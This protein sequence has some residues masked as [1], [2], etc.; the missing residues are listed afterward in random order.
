M[1]TSTPY[2]NLKEK[3]KVLVPNDI[4]NLDDGEEAELLEKCM[5][6]IHLNPEGSNVGYQKLR[7]LFLTKY[8]MNIH[9]QTAAR[10]NCSL[11]PEGVERQSKRVLKR[12]VFDVEGRDFIWSADGHDR[13]K[14]FGLTI[15]GFIDA[16]SRKILG[17]C[18]HTTN[19]NP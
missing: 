19:N 11:G 1:T 12:C 8:V 14:K 4:E 13:L 7:Q 3:F 17:I 9:L 18:V 2:K 10:P 15:Y 5:K 16:W 6:Q